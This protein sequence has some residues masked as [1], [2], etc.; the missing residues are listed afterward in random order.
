MERI[1]KATVN[2]QIVFGCLLLSIA[3]YI[4]SFSNEDIQ[5][6]DAGTQIVFDRFEFWVDTIL[7]TTG[8]NLIASTIYL[9]KIKPGSL[10]PKH[11]ALLVSLFKSTIFLLIVWG[12]SNQ[13]H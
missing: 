11:A 13:D 7:H 8:I 5:S 3:I 1:K 10:T 9:G 12:K 6:V 4:V 2:I